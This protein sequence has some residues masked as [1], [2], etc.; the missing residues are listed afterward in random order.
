VLAICG[1]GRGMMPAVTDLDGLE[2]A[3]PMVG[4][5]RTFPSEFLDP[6]DYLWAGPTVSNWEYLTISS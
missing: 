1:S 3:L 4:G 2:L 6:F 5:K